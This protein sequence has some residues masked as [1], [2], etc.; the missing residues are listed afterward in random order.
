MS[1]ARTA[2]RR[3]AAAAKTP[4]VATVSSNE[5]APIKAA[6]AEVAAAAA[7]NYP[8]RRKMPRYQMQK[9]LY[10][11]ADNCLGRVPMPYP[12]PDAKQGRLREA[13]VGAIDALEEAFDVIKDDLGRECDTDARDA[14]YVKFVEGLITQLG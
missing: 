8:G 12:R 6:F 10:R 13:M 5:L 14:L 9:A 1:T 2:R 3:K 7:A 4:L 11:A